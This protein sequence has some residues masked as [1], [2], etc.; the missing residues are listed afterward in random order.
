MIYG[1]FP[2]HVRHR[3][4]VQKSI[5]KKKNEGHTL[6]ILFILRLFKCRFK[7]RIYV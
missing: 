6:D 4:R 3:F 7:R 2:V 5:K 1:P